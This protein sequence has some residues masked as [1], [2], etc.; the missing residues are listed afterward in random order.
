[1]LYKGGAKYLVVLVGGDG[2][3]LGLGEN[4]RVLPSAPP[5]HV[6][7]FNDMNSGLVA[8]QR[9]QNYLGIKEKRNDSNC[10][11][12]THIHPYVH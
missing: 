8:M 1:M 7:G 2:D 5:Q 9:V 3:K 11:T 12:K 6:P 10:T 4:K